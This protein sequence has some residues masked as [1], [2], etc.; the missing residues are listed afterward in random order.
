MIPKLEL[1]NQAD[2]D[3]EEGELYNLPPSSGW[4]SPSTE[5]NIWA[6]GALRG[7]GGEKEEKEGGGEVAA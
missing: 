1:I 5:I 6:G 4:R 7:D 3:L 2:R